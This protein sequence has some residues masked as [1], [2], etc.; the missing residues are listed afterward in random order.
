MIENRKENYGLALD[1]W[2]AFYANNYPW[3]KNILN[4]YHSTDVDARI[5]RMLTAV[6]IKDPQCV[7]TDDHRR[8]VTILTELCPDLC[9]TAMRIDSIEAAALMEKYYCAN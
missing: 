6:L 5:H 8:L 3:L 9:F 1:K 2:D 4:S 7:I